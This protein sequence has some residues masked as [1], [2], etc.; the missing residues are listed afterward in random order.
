MI[1]KDSGGD[2]SGAE[3]D[4]NVEQEEIELDVVMVEDLEEDDD[5]GVDTDDE[6][7]KIHRENIEQNEA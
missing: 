4:V 1:F 3:D 7:E 5:G 6:D 2:D